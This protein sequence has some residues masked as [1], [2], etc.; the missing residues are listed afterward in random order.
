MERM[1]LKFIERLKALKSDLVLGGR[2]TTIRLVLTLGVLIRSMS[3]VHFINFLS[4]CRNFI[5]KVRCI[6]VSLSD[7]SS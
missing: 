6:W 7:A 2:Y 5:H 1:V 4:L 3:D